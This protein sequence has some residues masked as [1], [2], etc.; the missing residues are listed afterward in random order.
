MQIASRSLSCF[1]QLYR[2]AGIM[3]NSLSIVLGLAL[4]CAGTAFAAA[5]TSADYQYLKSEFGIQEGDEILANMSSSDAQGLHNLINDP[6]WKDY[7]GVRHDNIAD[8]LFSI[9]MRECQTWAQSHPGQECPPVADKKAEPGHQLANREC[10]ACHLFG[11]TAAPSFYKLA[12][13]GGWGEQKLA[14]A[15]KQGHQMSPM[16]LQPDQVKDL[17]AYIQSLNR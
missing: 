12:K 6:A 15:L 7:K 13:Q 1:R 9:H 8:R 17:A 16:T 5:L 14:A 10:S 11:T 3:R 2:T 4:L